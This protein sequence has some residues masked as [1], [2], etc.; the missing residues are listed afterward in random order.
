MPQYERT[1]PN[2]AK[3]IEHHSWHVHK[4][5]PG[6]TWEMF[7]VENG[8]N[9]ARL[10]VKCALSLGA[11]PADAEFRA[12]VPDADGSIITRYYVNG[13]WITPER[14]NRAG[15]TAED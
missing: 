4:R 12:T 11:V 13:F 7:C 6:G 2:G 9:A 10:Q 8:L 15:I 14:A 5:T 3:Y 1:A